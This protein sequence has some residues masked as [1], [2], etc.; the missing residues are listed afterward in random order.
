MMIES[1]PHRPLCGSRSNG[2]SAIRKMAG[3]AAAAPRTVR[4]TLVRVNRTLEKIA[5][6]RPV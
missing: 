2:Y 4:T 6:S 3:A 1:G 5:I